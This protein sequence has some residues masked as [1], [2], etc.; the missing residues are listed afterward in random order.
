VIIIKKFV[1]LS[2]SS[3]LT[4]SLAWGNTAPKTTLPNK[5]SQGT[6]F[7]IRA[8]THAYKNNPTLQNALRQYYADVEVIPQARAGWLPNLSVTGEGTHTRSYSDSF[9][10]TIVNTP[11]A[12]DTLR[13]S[14]KQ[15]DLSL[16]AN[17]TQNIYKGGQTYHGLR[18]AESKV[19]A[20]EM[21][22]LVAEQK[23]LLDAL[24][25]YLDLWKAQETLGARVAS[26][27]FNTRNL[28]EVQA[29][30]DVGEKSR[31]ELAEAESGLAG[32]IAARL[33]AEAELAAAKAKYQQNIGDEPPIQ[34]YEPGLIITAGNLPKS[35]KE[36]RELSE[37]KSPEILTAY[38]SEKQAVSTVSQAEGVL[39]PSVD[40]TADGTR[41]K[42]DAN[43]FQTVP[44]IAVNPARK[45]SY[46]NT[47][48]VTVRMTI[49][50]YQ[51]GSEWSNL[52][53]KNQLRYKELQN[54]RATRLAIGE[55]VAEVWRRWQAA[56]EALKQLEIQVK[57]AEI[58][59]EGRRQEHLVGERTLTD[60]LRAQDQL[61]TAQVNLIET[62]RNHM[63]FT[64]QILSLYG[65]LLPTTLNLP[66][67][68][69][70]VEGYTND[71]STR[72]FGVGDLRE[73]KAQEE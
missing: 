51:S 23:T 35:L 13:N 44:N 72:L 22:Y 5:P 36:F 61:V 1:A 29:Q 4:L 43:I 26:E 34:I 15:D 21:T 37:K 2:V 3:V 70:D 58:T 28:A 63:V 42:N 45:Y 59:L 9:D 7:F 47:G 49:P 73:I 8:L 27:N 66:V 10:S 52:R 56:K 18:A 69:F 33:Q 11:F 55:A 16:R 62:K 14:T 24:T 19:K 6:A 57:S 71:M 39:A 53:E 38:F 54:L 32:A 25:A 20:S 65:A 41:A 68:R 40:F 17:L 30:S 31:T 12:S 46:T 50:L 64:Y 60:V 48:R 67:E